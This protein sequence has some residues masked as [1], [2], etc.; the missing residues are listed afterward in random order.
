[1]AQRKDK[2]YSVGIDSKMTFNDSKKKDFKA[3][4]IKYI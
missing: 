4:I 1:M 3:A 2:S